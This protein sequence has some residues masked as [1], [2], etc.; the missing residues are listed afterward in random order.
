MMV[1]VTS[2][3]LLAVRWKGDAKAQEF[4]NE[5]LAVDSRMEADTMGT[6]ARMNLLW[7]QVRQSER[8]CLALHAWHE[9]PKEER[10]YQ[11]LIDKLLG[12]RSRRA[13][14]ISSR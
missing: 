1:E 7:N 2:A 3:D 11:E 13:T 10:T 14:R 6:R 12:L 9:K 5:W 8:V 4:L